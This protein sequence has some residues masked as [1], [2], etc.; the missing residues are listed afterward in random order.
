MHPA[1]GQCRVRLCHS[2]RT[3]WRCI[4]SQPLGSEAD[5]EVLVCLDLDPKPAQAPG[6]GDPA[7]PLAAATGH[8]DCHA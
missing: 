8:G 6:E 1:Q 7:P 5:N 2:T 3:C 4:T